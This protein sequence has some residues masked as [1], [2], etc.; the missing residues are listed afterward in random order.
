MRSNVQFNY[1]RKSQNNERKVQAT[2]T[3][4]LRKTNVKFKQ[5][6]QEISE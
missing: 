4:N 5:R 2:T 1:N 3:G 6:Q